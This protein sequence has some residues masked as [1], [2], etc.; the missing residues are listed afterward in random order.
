[1]WLD[2]NELLYDLLTRDALLIRNGQ[3][4]RLEGPFES[5]ER[6]LEAAQELEDRLAEQYVAA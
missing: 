6:A 2:R 4:Y 1:M 3:L 5:K